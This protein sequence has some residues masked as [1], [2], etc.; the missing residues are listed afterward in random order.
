MSDIPASDP[1]YQPPPW[2]NTQAPGAEPPMIAPPII[3]VYQWAPVI[4]LLNRAQLDI[5]NRESAA[6][7]A[8]AWTTFD[9]RQV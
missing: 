7:Q 1:A 2:P 3:P 4:A 6:R 9:E 5:L 8:A